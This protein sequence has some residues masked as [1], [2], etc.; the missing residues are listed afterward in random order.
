MEI[1][2]S[3]KIRVLRDTIYTLTRE[4]RRSTTTRTLDRLDAAL[5]VLSTS[6]KIDWGYIEDLVIE[7]ER[8]DTETEEK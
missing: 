3:E 7:A 6:E 5:R 1:R 2:V 4:D 8:L